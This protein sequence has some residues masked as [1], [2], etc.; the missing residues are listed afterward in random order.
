MP[1]DP[2]IWR[3][4]RNIFVAESDAEA[5][6]ALRD[7]ENK[8]NAAY[9]FEYIYD[10]VCSGGGKDY[11]LPPKLVGTA[12]GESYSQYDYMRDNFIYGNPDTVVEK[13]VSIREEVGPFGTFIVS[14]LDFPDR[15]LHKR[16]LSL[17]AK[18]VMPRLG[19]MDVD[20]VGK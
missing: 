11:I 5:E 10:M 15:E 16:S 2:E 1:F 19:Q 7:P 4:S 8:C 20:V 9:Y 17:I 6:A 3:V 13:L 18:E 12:A 14:A